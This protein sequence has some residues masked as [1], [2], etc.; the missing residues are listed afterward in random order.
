MVGQLNNTLGEPK[1]SNDQE[2]TNKER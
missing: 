2:L 1:T